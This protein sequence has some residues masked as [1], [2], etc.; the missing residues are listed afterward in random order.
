[1][2]NDQSSGQPFPVSFAALS[3]F[4]DDA[5]S[6]VAVLRKP[7]F[8]LFLKGDDDLSH[9]EV[10]QEARHCHVG[11][12]LCWSLAVFCEMFPEPGRNDGMKVGCELPRLYLGEAYCQWPWE[13]IR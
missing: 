8:S 2:I 3:E 7:D 9:F 6:L 4:A 5:A 12:E 10:P 13:A 1:M 11:K